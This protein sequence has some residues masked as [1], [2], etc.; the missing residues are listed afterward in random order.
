M[1]R[2]VV[3]AKDGP[4]LDLYPPTLIISKVVPANSP[5]V[6]APPKSVDTSSGWTVAHLKSVIAKALDLDPHT[7]S[8]LWHISEQYFDGTIT[9]DKLSDAELESAEDEDILRT[10]SLTDSC[11]LAFEQS[12][13]DGTWLVPPSTA[14]LASNITQPAPQAVFGGPSFF[15]DMQKRHTPLLTQAAPSTQQLTSSASSNNIRITR[16]HI[17]SNSKKGLVGLT[18]LGNTCFMN[19]ALQC[20]SNTPSLQTYFNSGLYKKELNPDNPLG[21]NGEVAR[22]FGLLIE[23][24]W[25]GNQSTVTPRE[26]KQTLS[27]FAP[28]FSGWQQHDSQ[29]LIAFLLDGLHEDLNRIKQKPYDDIPDWNGGGDKEEMQLGN[30]S[31]DLYK[32]RNDSVIVDLFQGQYRSGLVCPECKKVSQ[33]LKL[34]ESI[35]YIAMQ[36][37]IKFDPFMYLSLA[38]PQNRKWTGDVFLVPLD[39]KIPQKKVFYFDFQYLPNMLTFQHSMCLVRLRWNYH[40][41]PPSRR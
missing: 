15:D 19:S 13:S 18:N 5:R 27:K 25:A 33:Q 40:Q 11:H 24:I 32:K 9:S 8:R 28:A 16:N 3:L 21:M 2:E 39:P 35:A 34:R 36:V 20:L 12:N 37:A 26:F 6:P 41:M 29:E 7:K 31:W 17:G 22:A 38:I 30:T 4:I 14:L 1:K 23:K 10:S